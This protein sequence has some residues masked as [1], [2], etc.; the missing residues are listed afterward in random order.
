ME[1]IREVPETSKR[2]LKDQLN[3][4]YHNVTYM[5]KCTYW[6]SIDGY[7]SINIY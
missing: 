2:I 3:I 1:K 5:P 6:K 4:I 7:I